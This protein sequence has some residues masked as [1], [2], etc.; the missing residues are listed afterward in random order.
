MDHL[1]RGVHQH[2]DKAENPDPGGNLSKSA[3][4]W[5]FHAPLSG[6]FLGVDPAPGQQRRGYAADQTPLPTTCC[7][8]TPVFCH[9]YTMTSFNLLLFQAISAPTNGNAIVTAFAIFVNL[10]R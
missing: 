1:R 5:F 7:Q 8:P 9:S 3:C 2:A 6:G 4:R 10:V